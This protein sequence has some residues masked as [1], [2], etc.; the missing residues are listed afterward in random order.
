[1]G[2]YVTS[3]AVIPSILPGLPILCLYLDALA[4]VYV[5]NSLSL[6]SFSVTLWVVPNNIT[7]LWRLPSHRDDGTDLCFETTSE[8][9]SQRAG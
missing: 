2:P 5:V 7:R 1:M 8:T 9:P 4:L 3:S 6:L